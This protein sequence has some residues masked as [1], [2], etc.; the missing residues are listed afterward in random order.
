MTILK[1]PTAQSPGSTAKNSTAKQSKFKWPQSKLHHLE[2]LVHLEAVDLA[3]EAA[4]TLEVVVTVTLET[5]VPE[6]AEGIEELKL[7]SQLVP[8][9]GNVPSLTVA[10]QTSHGEMNATNAKHLNLPVLVAVIAKTV[11]AMEAGEA[12]VVAMAIVTVVAPEVVGIE[13]VVEEDLVA[14]EE[15]VAASEV[16]DV[17]VASEA[18]EAVTAALVVTVAVQCVVDAEAVIASVHIRSVPLLFC[19]FVK[20]YIPRRLT[21]TP[22]SF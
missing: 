13:V 17:E 1:Q 9:I 4:V 12:A 14:T 3:E 16:T 11:V 20:Y 6:V 18:V 19:L 22:R 8:E 7:T 2:A 10:T 5:V 15:A 21:Q